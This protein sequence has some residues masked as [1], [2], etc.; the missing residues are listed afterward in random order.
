MQTFFRVIAAGIGFFALGLQYY[1]VAAGPEAPDPVTWTI[2]FFSFFT[3]LTNCLAAVAMIVPVVAPGTAVGRFFDRPSARTA[4]A[5]Y[6]LIVGVVYH[7]VLRN[8]W[9]PQGW[10]LVADVLL[11]Y[12]TPALF[13]LDWLLFVPKGRVPWRTIFSAL[14]FPLAYI[15]W[16]LLHGAQTGWY[17]YPFVNVTELGLEKVLM[18]SAGLFGAFFAVTLLLTGINRLLGRVIGA[19]QGVQS[20]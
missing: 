2:N 4:I 8:I 19:G 7:L 5:A 12:V 18:N 3:I 17:P 14:A 11:H 9:D 15:G 1:I 13:L 16:T 6:I 10:A 20:T